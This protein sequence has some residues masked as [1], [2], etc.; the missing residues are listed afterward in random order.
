MFL[1]GIIYEISFL[2]PAVSPPSK[3]LRKSCKKD[4]KCITKS[5][6]SCKKDAKKMHKTNQIL[7]DCFDKEKDNMEQSVRE[8]YERFQIARNELHNYNNT[9]CNIFV[10]ILNGTNKSKLLKYKEHTRL[11]NINT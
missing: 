6:K 1:V 4:A 5:C 2:R 11:L 8:L 10:E 3:K 9:L 7:D